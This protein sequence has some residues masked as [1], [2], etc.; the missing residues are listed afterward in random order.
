MT[1]PSLAD[2]P[3][4]PYQFATEIDTDNENLTAN[5]GLD[6][7]FGSLQESPRPDTIF[8]DP[9]HEQLMKALL[10][11]TAL[12][13]SPIRANDEEWNKIMDISSNSVNLDVSD[14][15][16]CVNDPFPTLE[17]SPPGFTPGTTNTANN[18][19]TKSL[20]APDTSPATPYSN[21]RSI[22]ALEKSC[23]PPS[24]RVPKASLAAE[25]LTSDTANGENSAELR[26]ADSEFNGNGNDFAEPQYIEPKTPRRKTS[27]RHLLGSPFAPT[28]APAR[29]ATAALMDIFGSPIPACNRQLPT[30]N[31]STWSPI[32]REQSS[33]FGGPASNMIDPRYQ[34][35]SVKFNSPPNPSTLME[36]MRND[37]LLQN[38][39]SYPPAKRTRMSSVGA[40]QVVA[41]IESEWETQQYFYAQSH[42][43]PGTVDPGLCSSNNIGDMKNWIDSS[44]GDMLPPLS[45]TPDRNE[46][47]YPIPMPTGSF[48]GPKQEH[49]DHVKVGQKRTASQMMRGGMNTNLQ[50]SS[51]DMGHGYAETQDS[52][53]GL[54]IS[55]AQVKAPM[56]MEHK[57]QMQMSRQMQMQSASRMQGCTQRSAGSH[58]NSPSRAQTPTRLQLRGQKQQLQ[59]AMETQDQGQFL[60]ASPGQQMRILQQR[61]GQRGTPQNPIGTPLQMVG[62]SPSAA[63]TG[64]QGTPTPAPRGRSA[65]WKSGQNMVGTSLQTASPLAKKVQNAPGKRRVQ[66]HNRPV[67]DPKIG[68]PGGNVQVSNAQHMQTPG[69]IHQQIHAW[70][71]T[72]IETAAT[73]TPTPLRSHLPTPQQ[74]TST[75]SC[76]NTINE[77][78]EETNRRT[79][80]QLRGGVAP[81]MD[82]APIFDA[83]STVDDFLTSSLFPKS[84]NMSC[85]GVGLP[86][87]N[88]DF[89][90]MMGMDMNLDFDTDAD[91]NGLM[92]MGLPAHMNV[93]MCPINSPMIT[94]PS[95]TAAGPPLE[96]PLSNI[97]VR[98]PSIGYAETLQSETVVT[99]PTPI[100]VNNTDTGVNVN[101]YMDLNMP[102]NN[103]TNGSNVTPTSNVETTSPDSVAPLTPPDGGADVNGLAM[104]DVPTDF[105]WIQVFNESADFN[106]T[107]WGL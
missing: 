34:A 81:G 99:T 3:S 30:Q 20:T 71:H 61:R 39:L 104:L 107:D 45:T 8:Q 29:Q 24:L 86:L 96:H 35:P 94:S 84:N 60:Q 58:F 53:A 91:L 7:L 41:N 11:Y 85:G 16:L 38:E 2:I 46:Y 51:G 67:S 15:Q 72:P 62:S 21:S 28:T 83:S 97:D 55:Q 68:T 31:M 63:S 9:H 106:I 77:T 42:Q 5:D 50:S 23:T 37:T 12:S 56:L 105:D 93:N 6:N 90:D 88:I 92:S 100:P 87:L 49:E 74:L 75:G 103:V 76:P 64:P 79:G 27:A 89:T 78:V 70:N 101:A 1:D 22:Q 44:L 66:G 98:A 82:F 33:M 73:Q 14:T 4:H 32:T 52:L 18:R 47:D 80:A 17:S 54:F 95:G 10:D 26:F 13:P 19:T 36:K 57:N 48:E 65:L 102:G 25:G 43:G 59:T 40:Q 69:H